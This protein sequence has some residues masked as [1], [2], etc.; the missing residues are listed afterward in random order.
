MTKKLL[1]KFDTSIEIKAQATAHCSPFLSA[2]AAHLLTV[3]K[4]KLN[5]RQFDSATA[6]SVAVRQAADSLSDFL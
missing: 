6:R 3:H 4:L 5:V 2:Q 1:T